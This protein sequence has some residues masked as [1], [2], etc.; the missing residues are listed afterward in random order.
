MSPSPFRG[1]IERLLHFQRVSD[2]DKTEVYLCVLAGVVGVV[3]PDLVLVVQ[4]V[5]SLQPLHE[6]QVVLVPALA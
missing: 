6:L 3:L 2:L 5:V 4:V 1:Y